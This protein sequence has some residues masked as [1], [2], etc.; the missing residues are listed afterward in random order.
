[1]EFVARRM[2]YNDELMHYG[3]LGMKWGVRRKRDVNSISNN[4]KQHQNNS[5]SKK[6]KHR[7]ELEEKYRKKGYS[8][9]EAEFEAAKRIRTERI[10]AA[11]AGL[12]VAAATAYV[13]NKKIKEKADG[14]IKSGTSLQRIEAVSPSKLHDAF[15]A[16]KEKTDKTKYAGQLG[17]TR[18]RQAGKAY[19][20]N[21]GVHKDIKI[22]GKDKATEVFKK[23]YD[24]DTEFRNAASSLVQKNVHGKNSAN[25]NLKKMYENFNTNLVERDNPA[26]KKFYET[27]KSEGYGAIHDINDTKFSGY[28]AKNPL[29]VFGSSD[30]VSVSNI[31]ELTPHEA[32]KNYAKDQVREAAKESLTQIGA[33]GTIISGGAAASM[34]TEDR[35]KNNQQN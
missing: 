20:M 30:K 7:L 26:V 2:I 25:G 16:A 12:T 19:V 31:R 14:I 22:A 35:R 4:R 6:S 9:K 34:Y 29:I 32:Y 3:V 10:L 27:L 21:I 11:T 13:V 5:P 17:L 8:Q 28:K 23:L 1:M 33:Y 15:Y 24:T 18:Q